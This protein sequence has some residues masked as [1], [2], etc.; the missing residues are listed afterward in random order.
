VTIE[1]VDRVAVQPRQPIRPRLAAATLR[2][3]VLARLDPLTTIQARVD[4]RIRIPDGFRPV[5]PKHPLEEVLAVPTFAQPAW[6]LLRDH[7]PEHLL[8]G[9]RHVPA[10]TVSL[11]QTSQPFVEAFLIGL[12]HEI[13]RELLWREYPTDQRGTAFRRFWAPNGQDDIPPIHLWDRAS[14][15]GSTMLGGSQGH[16]VLLVRGD[17]LRRYPSTV[18]YAAPDKN[19]KPDLAGG[20]IKLPLFRGRMDPDVTFVGFDLTAMDA[21]DRWWFVFEEQPT[22]PRFALDVEDGFGEEAGPLNQWND[23]SWGHVVSSQAALT[24]LGNIRLTGFAPTQPPPPAPRWG[25]SASAM[26]AILVQQPVRVLF[27]G[28]TLLAGPSVG[29]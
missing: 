11:M 12:N 3:R 22:E 18:I 7:F 10:N 1:H 19:G 23:L 27:R 13:A 15:L 8:P 29:G 6:E 25:A 17:L 2:A 16:L 21:R 28:E 9:L 24:D 5:P 4:A 26:A 20:A 14:E